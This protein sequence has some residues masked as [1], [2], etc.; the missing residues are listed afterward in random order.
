[1]AGRRPEPTRKA[2]PTRHSP[3]TTTI[4]ISHSHEILFLNINGPHSAISIPDSAI[5][6]PNSAISFPSLQSWLSFATV[7]KVPFQIKT[8]RGLSNNVTPHSDTGRESTAHLRWRIQ[9]TERPCW[10]AS[11]LSITFRMEYIVAR[12]CQP[13]RRCG[14]TCNESWR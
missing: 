9:I 1:M 11:Q 7:P 12:Q 6:T 10:R 14:G 3:L 5:S 4:S 8:F 13:P 2:R